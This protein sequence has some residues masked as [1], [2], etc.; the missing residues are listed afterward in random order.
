M[1]C[2]VLF[3]CFKCFLATARRGTPDPSICQVEKITK[4]VQGHFGEKDT[5]AG[6]SDPAAAAKLEEGLK[7]S[8]GGG[9]VFTYPGVGHAFMNDLPEPY[10][11]FEARKVRPLGGEGR[12]GEARAAV[13]G[14]FGAPDVLRLFFFSFSRPPA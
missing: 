11:N 6:F 10:P 2:F 8:P 4:P 13:C 12:M 1:F 9:E 7:A 14:S 5:M 3:C